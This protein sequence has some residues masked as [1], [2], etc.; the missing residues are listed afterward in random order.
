MSDVRFQSNTCKA[1]TIFFQIPEF[2]IVCITVIYKLGTN[3]ILNNT[4]AVS[5]L[6]GQDTGCVAKF[7]SGPFHSIL[8]LKNIGTS[9]ERRFIKKSFWQDN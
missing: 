7:L 9:I 6:T 8:S 3:K 5:I 4:K 2:L 1:H